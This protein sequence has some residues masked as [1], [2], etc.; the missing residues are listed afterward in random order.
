MKMKYKSAV[1]MALAISL[2]GGSTAGGMPQENTRW[3][4]NAYAA[5]RDSDDDGEERTA[6]SS[7]ASREEQDKASASEAKRKD[8]DDETEPAEKSVKTATASNAAAAAATSSSATR[9]EAARKNSPLD[10]DTLNAVLDAYRSVPVFADVNGNE[11]SAGIPV[12]DTQSSFPYFSQKAGRTMGET[13]FEDIYGYQEKEYFLKGK[14]GIYG[15]EKGNTVVRSSYKKAT[16]SSASRRSGSDE[17]YINRVI[18]YMPEDMGSFSGKVFV[19]LLKESSRPD[20]AVWARSCDYFM[21][22]GYAYVGITADTDSLK[23]LKKFDS[24]RYGILKWGGSGL[25]EEDRNGLIWDMLGQLGVMLKDEE[26]SS[27]LGGASADKVYLLGAS[28]AGSLI[29][30]FV[31]CFGQANAAG[32]SE[33]ENGVS[34][35]DGFVNVAG[36][37]EDAPIGSRNQK[38]QDKKPYD[39]PVPFVVITGEGEFKS[40]YIGENSDTDE[41]KYRYYLVVGASYDSA[42]LP[43]APAAWIEFRAGKGAADAPEMKMD[44]ETKRPNT[45]TDLTMNAYI[46]SVL[47]NLIGWSEGGSMPEGF[48]A[49]E[50]QTDEN[51]RDSYGNLLNG[52]LPPQIAVPL[53]KYYEHAND[54]DS[55]IGGSMVYLSEEEMEEMYV[56]RDEYVESFRSAL[57]DLVSEGYLIGE[58]AEKIEE[59]A[60]NQ[61]I[62]GYRAS[63]FDEIETSMQRLPELTEISKEQKDGCCEIIYKASGTA[64]I[65]GVLFENIPYIKTAD[66]PY[67]NYIR[68]CIPEEFS[69]KAV[70]ELITKEDTPFDITKL[71]AEG[72]AFIGI[73][74]DPEAAEQKGGSWNVTE[75][76]GIPARKES[77]LLWDIISQTA[78]AAGTLLDGMPCE[79]VLG[80]EKDDKADAYTY[81]SVFSRFAG[82]LVN[83]IGVDE[84][85]ELDEP[86]KLSVLN[87]LDSTVPTLKSLLSLPTWSDVIKYQENDGGPIIGATMRNIIEKDGEFYKDSNGNNWVDIYE[88]WHY[89]SETRARDL[90]EK[91]TLWDKAGMMMINT[92]IMGKGGDYTKMFGKLQDMT[93]DASGLLN[94]TYIPVEIM[95][96][97]GLTSIFGNEAYVGTTAA[98]RGLRMRHFIARENPSAGNMAEWINQ[99]NLVAEND[100]LGIPVIVASNSR[101]ENGEETFGMNDAI[102]VFSTWP[103]TLGLAA[104]VIKDWQNGADLSD[105]LIREFAE[106]AGDEWNASGLK[107][108]YMY[109]ADTVTDPRWQRSYGAFSENPELNADIIGEVVEGFQKSDEGVQPDG[110][111]LTIKHFPGGGARENGFDPHYAEGKWNIYQTENSLQEYHLPAF[112]RAAEKNASSIMPYYAIPAL[113]RSEKQYDENGNVIPTNLVGFAFNREFITNILR[114]QLGF[115]GYVNSDSGIIGNMDWGVDH[116]EDVS[117][118]SALAVNAGTDIIGDTHNTSSIVKAVLRGRT[119]YYDSHAD[120][121]PEGYSAE[122]ITLTEG[123]LNEAN[124]RLLKEMFELGLFENPYRDPDEAE[125]VVAE[126][127]SNPAI[128]EAHQKSVVL[129][130]NTDGLLPLTEEKLKGKAV[131][132]HWFGM[133]DDDEGVKDDALIREKTAELIEG[134]GLGERGIKV[135]D[136]YTNADYALL[137]VYPSSGETFN[138]TEGFLELGICTNK[139]IPNVED[140]K[141]VSGTH[142]ISTISEADLIQ[143]IADAVHANG[144]KVISSVNVSLAWLV[145]NVETCSDAML[146]GFYTL[147]SATMDV[148]TGEVNPSGRLPLTLPKDDSVIEVNED[149]ICVSHND[150]PGYVKDRYMPENMKDGNGKAYAYRDTDGNYYEFGFGLEYGE[151]GETPVDPG[152]TDKPGTGDGSEAEPGTGGFGSGSG[153]SHSSG[154]GGGSGSG[155]RVYTSA[156]NTAGTWKHDDKGWW[157]EYTDHTWPAGQWKQLVWNHIRSWYYFDADGYMA[158]G[159]LKD[160]DHMYYLHPHA[161]GTQGYMYV[162]WHLI[163]GKWY[164]FSEVPGEALGHLLTDTETPDGC[165]VGADGVWIP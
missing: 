91:M 83:G 23:T 146:A 152:D 8:R 105:S 72:I 82:F 109:M 9:S 98:I 35:Y 141:P 81:Y 3:L 138:A 21:R 5:N 56:S 42:D 59:I 129:L 55:E 84:I 154:T 160:G 62:F 126:A 135:T 119:G 117:M 49:D 41:N 30:T 18:V 25:S 1:A 50:I 14:A 53:A 11:V 15:L 22:N 44:K 114:E 26:G 63:W 16:G 88:D 33:D 80:I 67:E 34:V 4:L 111:A 10:E 58:E 95:K 150:I 153:G 102:G 77:G 28:E 132:V 124:V 87:S 163:N 144:G 36:S 65:Y 140:G 108:G 139:E 48:A 136:N 12:A 45:R 85:Q 79:L 61:P 127:R 148:I 24:D 74:A 89:D 118:K 17:S 39:S 70:I 13:G 86:N 52:I 64:N 156:P 43:A 51:G 120:E 151:G 54:K 73:T 137:F 103:G 161:D 131:Y 107:K 143:E 40:E 122:Q 165:R 155:G 116:F 46:N 71:K 134:L 123:R 90:V 19:D 66:V 100:R 162:G 101:N 47:D 145:G 149:G 7:E 75:G 94:E 157:F 69:G 57:E 130:K 38:R 104:A 147:P 27:L 164:Y 110:V 159:W 78:T 113:D 112:E 115:K 106:T 158:T 37:L 6:S 96:K 97:I 76:E 31:N 93:T 142:L 32:I 20:A 121:I 29:N 2:A 125:S 68:V 128:E 99:M 60:L 133:A 92:K